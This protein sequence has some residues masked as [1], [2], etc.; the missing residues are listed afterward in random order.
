MAAYAV[1]GKPAQK[2]SFGSVVSWQ[3][4]TQHRGLL[5]QTDR[6]HK[7][8][9]MVASGGHLVNTTATKKAV[10]F[11]E[12]LT[13]AGDPRPINVLDLNL[14]GQQETRKC[15]TPIAHYCT[16]VN[17]CDRGV[18]RPAIYHSDLSCAPLS[19]HPVD[20]ALSRRLRPMLR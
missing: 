5:T 12:S 3:N 6:V 16:A 17:D 7:K 4:F 8:L 18:A 19:F 13:L 11:A 14:I 15:I 20:A 1:F 9:G 10:G 2:Q